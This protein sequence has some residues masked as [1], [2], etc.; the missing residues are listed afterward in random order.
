VRTG[1]AQVRR[2]RA[3]LMRPITQNLPE[4]GD[5]IEGAPSLADLVPEIPDRAT[6]AEPGRTGAAQELASG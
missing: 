1:T 6:V 4:L 2:R 3:D 5:V